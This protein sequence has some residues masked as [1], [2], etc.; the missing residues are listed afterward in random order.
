LMI[1]LA[2]FDKPWERYRCQ[3]TH[4]HLI[5]CRVLDDLRAQV[6]ALDRSQVLMVRLT[7][8]CILV[9]H[10][11][12]ACLDLRLN[13]LEPQLLSGNTP[14]SLAFLLITR[15]ERFELVAKAKVQPR[16]LVRTEQR[17]LLICFDTL[18]KEIRYPQ[19][20]E[21]IASPQLILAKVFAQVQ[22]V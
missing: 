21:K 20:R 8:A 10:E 6:A 18:H 7:V 1:E 16:R 14:T 13:D 4:R 9:E 15:V 2:L 22:E 19:S 3:V 12:S 5:G 11:R 17:P